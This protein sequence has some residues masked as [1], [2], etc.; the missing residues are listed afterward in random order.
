MRRFRQ[1]LA[2]LIALASLMVLFFGILQW[3]VNTPEDHL[4]F[5]RVAA[6]TTAR[7]EQ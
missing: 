2:G 4:S 1:I 7:A 5:G 3:R 6:G